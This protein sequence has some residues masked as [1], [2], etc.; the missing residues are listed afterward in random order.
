ML[1]IP[2]GTFAGELEEMFRELDF[3]ESSFAFAAVQPTTSENRKHI[4]ERINAFHQRVIILQRKLTQNRIPGSP[5]LVSASMEMQQIFN[6]IRISSVKRIP[7]FRGTGLGSYSK[8]FKK[9]MRY[10]KN[11]R[12]R[13]ELPQYPTLRNININSYKVWL[14]NTA[15]TYIQTLQR[16]SRKQIPANISQRL[17]WLVQQIVELRI[18]LARLAQNKHYNEKILG[19]K[20]AKPAS[21]AG[22]DNQIK[23]TGKTNVSKNN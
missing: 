15:Q 17:E 23:K 19:K 9:Y 12:K 18:G 10:R 3:I 4:E 11:D 13:Q 14:E 7:R 2:A 5:N 22:A 8:E 6:S 21:A 20:T 16:N 1:C